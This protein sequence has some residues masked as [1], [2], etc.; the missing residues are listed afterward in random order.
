MIKKENKKEKRM[1]KKKIWRR[2]NFRRKR[3]M[4]RKETR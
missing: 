4:K 3:V 2:N 1:G